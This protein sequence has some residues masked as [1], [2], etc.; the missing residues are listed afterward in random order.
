MAYMQIID[1]DPANETQYKVRWAK[2]LNDSI[3]YESYE[4]FFGKLSEL[5]AAALAPYF[6]H[7]SRDR[8]QQHND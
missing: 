2:E 6:E 7:E 5:L 4:L 3:P 1:V 8:E